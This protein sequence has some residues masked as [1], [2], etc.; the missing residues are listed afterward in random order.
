MDD[1]PLK[2]LLAVIGVAQVVMLAYF[3]YRQNVASAN[4]RE[5]HELVNGLSHEKTEA[6][7]DAASARGELTGRDFRTAHPYPIPITSAEE[8]AIEQARKEG[9]AEGWRQSGISQNP[10]V[11][12]KR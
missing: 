11:E 9:I 6:A 3:T 8:S 2:F 5:V 10:P 1:N 7:V 12:D 4:L